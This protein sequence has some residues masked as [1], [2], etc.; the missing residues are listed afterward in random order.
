MESLTVA[1]NTTNAAAKRYFHNRSMY[2]IIV[3]FDSNSLSPQDS[4]LLSSLYRIIYEF[5][6]ENVP[7][8]PPLLLAGGYNGFKDFILSLP[9]KERLPMSDSTSDTFQNYSSN[10]SSNLDYHKTTTDY[11]LSFFSFSTIR[12]ID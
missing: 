5:E 6:F 9:S 3:Y 4:P 11:V 7:K 8:Q 2:D 12:S 1:F 10:S